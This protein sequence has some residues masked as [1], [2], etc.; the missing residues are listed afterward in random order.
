MVSSDTGKEKEHSKV[1][2]RCG[3]IFCATLIAAAKQNYF[4][5]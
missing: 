5:E 2:E 1:C 3:S 4:I